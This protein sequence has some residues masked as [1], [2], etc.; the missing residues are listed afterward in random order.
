MKKLYILLFSSLLIASCSSTKNAGTST[1]EMVKSAV[2][3]KRY[4]V[5]IDRLYG[6]NGAHFELLPRSNF[7]IIDGEKAII[8]A[9]YFGSQYDI[10]PI[11][12]LNMRGIAQDY[13]LT[14]KPSKGSYDIQLRMT[15]SSGTTFKVFLSVSKKGQCNA[16]VSGLKIESIR[17]TGHL[18]P[19]PETYQ[20]QQQAPFPDEA[21]I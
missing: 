5:K 1:D 8:S 10:K 18:V 11:V 13:Q 15:N 2:E 4:I 14:S 16:S 9:A 12:G 20:P 21:T 17:Y 7:I 6:R 19:I 3:S